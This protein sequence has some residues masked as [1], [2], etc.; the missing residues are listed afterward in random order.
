MDQNECLFYLKEAEK[1]WIYYKGNCSDT[2]K[3]M[4]FSRQSNYDRIPTLSFKDFC[5][6]CKFFS[7][8]KQVFSTI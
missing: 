8:A 5:M 3:Q 7:Q 1:S 6:L 2:E 4:L